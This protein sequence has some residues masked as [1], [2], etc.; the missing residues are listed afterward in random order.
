MSDEM[1]SLAC[2]MTCAYGAVAPSGIPGR[3]KVYSC[4]DGGRGGG[5]ESKGDYTIFPGN[6]QG[7]AK[8][9]IVRKSRKTTADI[10]IYQVLF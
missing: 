5:D 6:K 10:Y 7:I 9:L 1:V 2:P 4:R 3:Y 8:L